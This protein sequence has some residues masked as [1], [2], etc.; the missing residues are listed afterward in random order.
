MNNIK[1]RLKEIKK[2]IENESISYSEIV[3]LESLKEYIDKDDILL[4]QWANVDEKN[5]NNQK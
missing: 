5:Y 1:K 3:E 4:L 2:E